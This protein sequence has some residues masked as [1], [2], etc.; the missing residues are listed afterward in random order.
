MIWQLVAMVIAVK[1]ALDYQKTEKAVL[2]CVIGW[3]A[4]MAAVF[5]FGSI[6]GLGAALS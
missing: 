3:V 4:Y 5:L 2:V 6:L 1:A